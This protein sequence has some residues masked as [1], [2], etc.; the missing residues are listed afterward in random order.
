MN[1]AMAQRVRKDSVGRYNHPDVL[2]D[3]VPNTLICP[4]IDIVHTSQGFSLH[5]GDLIADDLMLL[6]TQCY[7][8]DKKPNQLEFVQSK[9]TQGLIHHHTLFGGQAS[10]SEIIRRIA[11]IGIC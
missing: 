8:R 4:T 10:S 3:L 1:E 5:R 6:E 7:S 2:E 9:K 11:L